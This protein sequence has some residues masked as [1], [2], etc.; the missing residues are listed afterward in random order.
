MNDYLHVY[1]RTIHYPI[2]GRM[3]FS[4]RRYDHFLIG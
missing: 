4:V 3:P 1:E 2:S